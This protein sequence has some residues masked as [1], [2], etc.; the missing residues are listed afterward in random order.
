MPFECPD[1]KKVITGRNRNSHMR[2]HESERA[3]NDMTSTVTDFH[4]TEFGYKRQKVNQSNSCNLYLQSDVDVR[5]DVV[6]NDDVDEGKTDFGSP[7]YDDNNDMDFEVPN[8]DN[9]HKVYIIP[10]SDNDDFEIMDKKNE[11]I[12]TIFKKHNVTQST[13]NDIVKWY[14]KFKKEGKRFSYCYRFWVTENLFN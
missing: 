2:L 13:I 8:D 11:E 14:N 4:E 1:C 3:I 5:D 6:V 10:E 12:H 9:F 7:F